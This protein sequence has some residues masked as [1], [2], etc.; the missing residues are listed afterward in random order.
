MIIVTK[1]PLGRIA[2]TVNIIEKVDLSDILLLLQRHAQCDWGDV[3]EGDRLKNQQALDEGSR[4]V[5]SYEMGNGTSIW[6]VTEGDRSATT[7]LFP[8]DY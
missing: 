5:S 3:E 2:A 1:F 4:L 8:S 7:V 6:I